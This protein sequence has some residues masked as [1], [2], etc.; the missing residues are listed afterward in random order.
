MV[1]RGDRKSE[2]KPVR[3]SGISIC[4]FSPESYVLL[5][6]LAGLLTF[7]ACRLLP[8]PQGLEQW[9]FA[10]SVSCKCRTG[11]QLRG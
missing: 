4:R 7:L 8:I 1:T 3:R 10:D 11:S 6:D 2:W 5:F 9:L